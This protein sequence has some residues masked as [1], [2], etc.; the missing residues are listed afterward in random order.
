MT[1]F[2]ESI[3]KRE[4]KKNSKALQNLSKSS[5][6]YFWNYFK[7]VISVLGYKNEFHVR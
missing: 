6:N 7:L 2:C 1:I 4:G 5:P 3:V